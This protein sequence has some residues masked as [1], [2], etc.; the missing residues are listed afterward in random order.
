MILRQVAKN[1]TIHL[2]GVAIE[3]K[4]IK[5]KKIHINEMNEDVLHN[6]DVGTYNSSNEENLNSDAEI[7][8]LRLVAH[9][10]SSSQ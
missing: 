7:D 6:V 1:L 10:V 5:M 9:P 3:W 2:M 4:N 8:L